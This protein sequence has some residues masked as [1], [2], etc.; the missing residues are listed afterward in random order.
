M[1]WK[2]GEDTVT[3]HILNITGRRQ[4]YDISKCPGYETCG[5]SGG[6]REMQKGIRQR[7]CFPRQGVGNVT[8]EIHGS[9]CSA[10]EIPSVSNSNDHLEIMTSFRMP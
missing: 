1:C 2:Y 9:A 6:H 3:S 4:C 10:T 5:Q 7:E 8:C